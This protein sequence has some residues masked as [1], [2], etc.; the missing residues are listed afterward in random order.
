MKFKA[1]VDFLLQNGAAII[2]VE[3]KSAHSVAGKSL[4]LYNELYKQL[5]VFDF[6]SII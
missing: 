5:Y 6:L 2:P 1:E 3:V 4:A